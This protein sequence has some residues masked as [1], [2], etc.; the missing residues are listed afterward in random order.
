M[1]LAYISNLTNELSFKTFIQNMYVYPQ[2][3]Q[4]TFSPIYDANPN[5]KP[6]KSHVMKAEL[7]YGIADL[8]NQPIRER[9]KRMISIAHPDF[10]QQLIQEALGAKLIRDCD[11]AGIIA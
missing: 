2:I 11:A 6:S 9:V 8:Y 4:T 10:R 7:E 1:R 3:A 5:L